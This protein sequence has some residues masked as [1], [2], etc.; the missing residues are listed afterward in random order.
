MMPNH[1][2]PP[3]ADEGLR[4]LLAE[5]YFIYVVNESDNLIY[6]YDTERWEEW[7]SINL[8]E[9][10]RDEIGTAAMIQFSHRY[11]PKRVAKIQYGNT[12]C[13]DPA[14]QMTLADWKGGVA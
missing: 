9:A 10:L 6:A 12:W 3:Y 2:A 11:T 13:V 8:R 1:E 7:A 14:H 4:V 5:D